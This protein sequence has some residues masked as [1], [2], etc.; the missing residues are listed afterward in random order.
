MRL[1]KRIMSLFIIG[2][3]ALFLVIV[4]GTQVYKGIEKHKL[5]QEEG[6]ETTAIVT[7]ITIG[8]G[9]MGGIF[10]YYQFYDMNNNLIE[11]KEEVGR[12]LLNNIKKGD[13][14]QIKYYKKDPSIN[15]IIGNTAPLTTRKV[16]LGFFTIMLLFILAIT[17]RDLKR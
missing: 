12:E 14:I 10:F 11:S 6:I 1:N 13:E 2:L 7:D 8:G 15:G 9:R 4:S 3:I 17:I 5:L 16:F